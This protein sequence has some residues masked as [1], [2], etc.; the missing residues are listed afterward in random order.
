MGNCASAKNAI[1]PIDA[2]DD[3]VDVSSESFGN[4]NADSR[5]VSAINEEIIKAR[6]EAE[7]VAVKEALQRIEGHK[8]PWAV[9]R[10]MQKHRANADAQG[11]GCRILSTILSNKQAHAVVIGNVT[12]VI[13]AMEAH[14]DSDVQEQ[15]CRVLMK[16]AAH[17]NWQELVVAQNGGI[18]AILGAMRTHASHAGIQWRG[19]GALMNLALHKNNTAQVSRPP[20]LPTPPVF[21]H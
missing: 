19:A 16:L 17:S 15:G 12:T 5:P 3:A 14:R 21:P 4:P 20:H 1:V 9:M 6:G 10:M 13:R 2:N 7:V 18:E 11:T 8:E